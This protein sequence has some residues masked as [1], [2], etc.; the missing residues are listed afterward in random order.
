MRMTTA[1]IVSLQFFASGSALSA[2]ARIPFPEALDAAVVSQD[3]LDDIARRSL[4]L[5]NGD[6]NALLW[7]SGDAIR[8]RVTKNDL[9]DARIDTSKDPELL[10]MDLRRRTWRGGT[11]V[12]ASWHK[13]PYPQPRCAAVVVIGQASPTARAWT[14]IRAEGTQNDWSSRKGLA[15][16][17]VT[18]RPE[19]SAGWRLGFGK[20]SAAACSAVRLQIS[21]TPNARYY[22][23]VADAAGKELVRS[24]WRKTPAKQEEVTFAFSAKRAPGT[25]ELY[26]MSAD[27][28]RAENRYRRI[29]LTGDAKPREVDLA[30]ISA[31][32]ATSVRLDLRR[33]VAT[34]KG[35][36]G[37]TSTVRAL[38]DRHV[39]L[40]HSPAAVSL[41]EVKAPQLPPARRGQTGG[42]KWLHM[43]MPGDLDYRGMQYAMAVA[44]TGDV[45][46]V[47]MVTSFDTDGKVLEAAIRLARETVATAPAALVAKHEQAWAKFWSASGL[48]LGD[49]FF[50]DAWYRNLYYMRCFCRPGTTMPITLYAGLAQDRTGWH[51][52]PTLDYNIQQTFWPMFVCNQV[53]LME[54]YVTYLEGFAPRGR[55]L[56]K[57]TYGVDGLFYPVNIFGPEYLVSPDKA[58]S[59]NG[60]QIAYVPW[61]YGLGLTGW[62]LQNL[63]LRYKYQPEE[64]YLKRV[65]PLLRDGAEFYANVLAQCRTGANGKAEIGPSYNPEHGPFGTYN[66]PVDIAYFRFLLTVAGEAARLLNR[67]AKLARRWA[68][69]LKRVGDYETTPLSTGPI[70]ANWKGATANS[71][72]VHNVA[73]PTV[74]IFPGEQVSWFSPPA[75]KKLFERTLRWIRHNGNNSHIMVNVARA[76]LSFPQA[77][78]ATRA[79]FSKIVTPNGLYASWP[80]HG[81]FLA[82]SWA[83]A[84]L[85]AELLLQSVEDIVRVFPA[86]PT[87]QDAK[88]VNLRAQG[89]FLVS[90]EQKGGMVLYVSVTS[91]AGGTLRVLSPWPRATVR[92]AG[93]TAALAADKRDILTIDTTAGQELRLEAAP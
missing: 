37:A 75:K 32:R 56:A 87:E 66:N 52:A 3:R 17:S 1:L 26:V 86:W 31:R 22:V 10:R 19:T 20:S 15:V 57:K 48:A 49:R 13:H 84:G 65:Y 59:K 74:P 40:I 62:A 68:D 51:G 71:V 6:L 73:V 39:F 18:G 81:Y 76:R 88:F 42:V 78:T 43:T 46:A 83:F 89:G 7:D 11:R 82:E 70:V 90:A 12:P 60:R 30:R 79:H 92:R 63:W 85:T 69:Q 91:T 38:A 80:G 8:M 41:E 44:G 25:L 36:G 54:P 64:A 67:D 93:R 55:W 50:Q 9:W 4:V 61:T 23:Y 35:T 2:E 47:S 14:R 16:M 28:K 77:Y 72:R 21:G 53:D 34:V 33:A 45:K 27:G 29:A 24:G 5:G 58:R